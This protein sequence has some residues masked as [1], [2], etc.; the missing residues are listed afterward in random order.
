MK[1]QKEAQNPEGP[2]WEK[3]NIMLQTQLRGFDI[4][5]ATGSFTKIFKR[6]RRGLT[7]ESITS[8]ASGLNGN[9]SGNQIK[10]FE[11]IDV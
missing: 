8:R 11:L 5:K 4:S 9:H 7:N 6:E 2:V 1:L 10:D 3:K